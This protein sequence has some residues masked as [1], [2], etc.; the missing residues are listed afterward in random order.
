MNVYNELYLNL[1]PKNLKF[2]REARISAIF[3][4]LV[5]LFNLDLFKTES[6]FRQGVLNN[7]Y[8]KSQHGT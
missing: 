5:C 8:P 7:H 4:L 3:F 1:S 2:P 6:L